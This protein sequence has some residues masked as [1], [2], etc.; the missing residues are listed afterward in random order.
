MSDKKRF[1]ISLPGEIASQLDMLASSYSASR[2]KLVEDA[3]VEYLHSEKHLHTPHKCRGVFIALG[4]EPDIASV[5]RKVERFCRVVFANII[6]VWED[7][8]L[9]IVGIEGSSADLVEA[10][11]ELFKDFSEVKYVPLGCAISGQSSRHGK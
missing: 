5:V 1:G 9:L 2:S 11:K 6:G 8:K 10:R 7:T 3:I 4:K